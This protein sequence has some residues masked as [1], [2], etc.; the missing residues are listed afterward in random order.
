MPGMPACDMDAED[1]VVQD[2]GQAASL[3]EEQMLETL[4]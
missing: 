4:I 3:P 2:D 1:E